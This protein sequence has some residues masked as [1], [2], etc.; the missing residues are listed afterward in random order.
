MLL[1]AKWV[2]TAM[3]ANYT[4]NLL[5]TLRARGAIANDRV[6]CLYCRLYITQETLNTHIAKRMLTT[7]RGIINGK[8]H[9]FGNPCY[10][11]WTGIPDSPSSGESR[12]A[13]PSGRKPNRPVICNLNIINYNHVLFTVFILRNLNSLLLTDRI[14]CRS[15]FFGD[16]TCSLIAAASHCPR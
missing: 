8:S 15:L 12:L 6:V 14:R 4:S 2:V 13:E 7:E 9:L 3:V 16:D 10:L 11:I 5:Q 1:K